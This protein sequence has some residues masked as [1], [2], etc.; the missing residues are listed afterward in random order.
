MQITLNIVTGKDENGNDITEKKIFVVDHL[1]ARMVRRALEITDNVDFNNMKSTDLDDMLNYVVEIY[2][3]QFT[4][5][6]IYD[7][8]ESCEL[9]PT[10]LKCVNDVVGTMG[11]KIENISK[12]A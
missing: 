6:D 4:I 7:G 3:N 8:L 11:A 5:D 10:I 2:R 12:N 1:K 9:M